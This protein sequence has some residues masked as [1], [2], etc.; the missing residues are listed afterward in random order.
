M[1]VSASAV[2]AL[3]LLPSTGAFVS[4]FKKSASVSELNL[5]A[6]KNAWV[7]PTATAVAGLALA[8]Q[9]AAAAPVQAVDASTIIPPMITQG[10]NQNL[11]LRLRPV[12]FVTVTPQRRIVLFFFVF[13]RYVSAIN[14]SL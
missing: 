7:G 9:M 12:I 8:S 5:Q 2:L 1:K 10:R 11:P 6:D 3:S 14:A 13:N 4:T